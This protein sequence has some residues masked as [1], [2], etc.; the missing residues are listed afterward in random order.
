MSTNNLTAERL[1]SMSA[2]EIAGL[3]RVRIYCSDC[4]DCSDCYSCTGCAGC[5]DCY[6]CYNCTRC[7]GC[8]DCS[9]CY[10]IIGGK[11]LQHVAFGVQLTAEQYNQFLSNYGV[12]S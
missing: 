3:Q 12:R 4:S 11:N 1:L 9:C 2:D 8:S 6:G 7:T 5:A 10:G